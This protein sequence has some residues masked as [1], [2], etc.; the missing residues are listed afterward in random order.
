MDTFKERQQLEELYNRGHAPWEIW[1]AP[2]RQQS[3]SVLR[4]AL[5]RRD[6]ELVAA[7]ALR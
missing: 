3:P 1:K 6:G 7:Q 5:V 4:P 2:V